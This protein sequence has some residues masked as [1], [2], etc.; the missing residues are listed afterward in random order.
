[1]LDNLKVSISVFEIRRY[2]KFEEFSLHV[3]DTVAKATREGSRVLLLPEFLPMGLLWTHPEAETVSN[4]TV[5]DF[6]R[7][8]L[9]PL[10]PH[11][12]ALLSS[13]AKQYDIYLVGATYWHEEEGKGL[14]S[15]FVFNP[16]GT[17]LRQNKVHLT[18]GELAIQTSGATELN[19]VFT[20]DGVKCG[21]YVCYDVQFPELTRHFVAQGAE[22][23]F[24]PA[25]TEERGSWREW[26]SAHARALENQAYV[27]VSPLVGHLG[28]PHDYPVSCMGKAFVACPID[29]RFKVTDGT[30]AESAFDQPGLLTVDLDLALLRLSREKGEVRHLRDRRPELY[31]SLQS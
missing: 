25:L 20:I 27:C 23:I 12:V 3:E 5:S 24:V 7:Q 10:Y 21:L 26:H 8:V 1:M 31:Q 29:N 2:R 13:L 4:Q 15:A 30:Y 14:N 6:Y 9:T 17:V 11:F 16:D 28:I 22:V 18:R 19:D